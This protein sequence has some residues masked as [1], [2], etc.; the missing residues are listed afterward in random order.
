M[1]QVSKRAKW[2]LTAV[3]LVIT[4]LHLIPYYIL[5]TTAFKRAGD[6]SSKWLF[7]DY[8]SFEN[9]T[10]A[11][12]QAN[13]SNAF[14]NTFVITFFAAAMLILFGSLAA[15]AL[16][17]RQTR[18]NKYVYML[19]VAVMVI[20]PLTALVPLYQ[21]VV[22]VG[23][24]N[25]RLVAVLNNVA[26]FLPLT[27][28][29]YA[30]FIRST[31]PKEL[32]EAAKMDGASTIGIFFRVVFPLLKPIT[33]TVLILSCVYIWNDYQFAIFFLQDSDMHTLTVALASFF[34]QNTSQLGLVGAA[35]LIASLPMVFLFLFLQRFFIEGLA[36]GS[37]KG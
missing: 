13:L 33:A 27:I 17:R 30:G 15:Y 23:L 11:W 24:M 31:V 22:D 37:V 26:A 20:P 2:Y 19:F 7:P 21:L 14:M 4:L 8:F 6:F 5:L 32:E 12:E 29:L 1:N 35:A 25:T 16:A 3:A 28:F 10:N 18:L 9:F 36:A 34:G